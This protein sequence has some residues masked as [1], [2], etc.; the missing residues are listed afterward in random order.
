[1]NESADGYPTRSRTSNH[2]SKERHSLSIEKWIKTVLISIF[3]RDGSYYC[4]QELFSK[5]SSKLA[6]INCTILPISAGELN[7]TTL[8][9][10]LLE[11]L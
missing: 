11:I 9:P 2:C 1:M 10:P 4:K 6:I 8:D 3:F 7:V 5:L